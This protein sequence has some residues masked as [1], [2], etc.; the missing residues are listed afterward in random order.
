MLGAPLFWQE[1]DW[2]PKILCRTWTLNPNTVTVTDSFW[3]IIVPNR[4]TL[5]HHDASLMHQ[6]LMHRWCMHE[7]IDASLMRGGI[8]RC[9][10]DAGHCII[11]TSL[12]RGLDNWC[13]IDAG[14]WRIDAS[15]IFPRDNRCIIDSGGQI[16]DASMMRPA[17]IAKIVVPE[18]LL[19][20]DP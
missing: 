7:I 11:D 19:M 4:F 12:M 9:I 2:L 8:N 10:I 20:R 16:I 15:L 5:L 6:M 1:C 14:G 17:E 3:C 13:I 18:I